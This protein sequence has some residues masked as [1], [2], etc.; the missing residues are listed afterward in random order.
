MW[1]VVVKFK[2]LE[3]EVADEGSLSDCLSVLGQLTAHQLMAAHVEAIRVEWAD[4]GK[5]GPPTWSEVIGL[6]VGQAPA[7]GAKILTPRPSG[8]VNLGKIRSPSA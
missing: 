8:P 4:P 5:Q 1:R 7:Q 6:K 2:T 3:Q